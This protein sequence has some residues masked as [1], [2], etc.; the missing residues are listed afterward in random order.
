MTM[1]ELKN[2]MEGLGKR[3]S[4]D[5]DFHRYF[6]DAFALFNSGDRSMIQEIQKNPFFASPV[7]KA[8]APAQ[9]PEPEAAGAKR[10]RDQDAVLLDL[11][12][13]ERRMTIQERQMT[14]QERQMTLREK[15]LVI[16]GI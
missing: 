8:P 15:T 13:Q 10:M 4:R 12:L 6:R 7:P 5:H 9:E 1:D 3:V 16:D 11:K 2:L 14:L